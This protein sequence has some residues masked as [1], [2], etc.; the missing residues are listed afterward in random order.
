MTRRH[1]SDPSQKQASSIRRQASVTDEHTEESFA[2]QSPPQTPH[3]IIG[4]AVCADGLASLQAMLKQIPIG[5]GAAI[6]L[7][8]HNAIDTTQALIEMLSE[9]TDL[10]VN[11]VCDRERLTAD[12]I[13]LVPFGT[14]VSIFSGQFHVSSRPIT[15]INVSE[16][17]ALQPIDVFWY[18]LA[19]E[20]ADGSVGVILC[21]AQYAGPIGLRAIEDVGG[22]TI[23]QTDDP[24]E[25]DSMQ[26]IA[27]RDG[28]KSQLLGTCE[29]ADTLLARAA[30]IASATNQPHTPPQIY[31][32]T[33]HAPELNKQHLNRP[34]ENG[35]PPNGQVCCL[36]GPHQS[37]IQ[38][39]AIVLDDS[40]VIRRFTPAV[41]QIYGV[42]ES[43]IGRPLDHFKPFTDE[44]PPLP[45]WQSI[46]SGS[47]QEHS[48]C[49]HM[50][51]YFV[52]R[53]SPYR[54][55]EGDA[56]NCDREFMLL[57]FTEVTPSQGT[58]LGIA[59]RCQAFRPV[60]DAAPMV[61]AY[62]DTG[63]NFHFAKMASTGRIAPAP[64]ATSKKGAD[65]NNKLPA[66][67]WLVGNLARESIAACLGENY[68]DAMKPH[69]ES[70]L[71]GL[72]QV[73]E[74]DVCLPEDGGI[75]TKQVAY[76][77]DMGEAGNYCGCY[78]VVT[79]HQKAL[80]DVQR[81][82]QRLEHLVDAANVGIIF[83]ESDGEVVRLNDAMLDLL[84]LSREGFEAD[85]L[86]WRQLDPFVDSERGSG[87]LE[88]LLR[89]ASIVQ[90]QT[91][92]KCLDGSS[93]TVMLHGQ[94][95]LE[96][97]DEYVI[98]VSNLTP[99]LIQQQ[100]IRDSETRYRSLTQ[101]T[102]TA[103]WS[104]DARG[105]LASN[106]PLW[107]NV[108]D[109]KASQQRDLGWIDAFHPDDRSS[110]RDAWLWAVK[111]GKT[112]AI[113]ARL[114]HR[115][116]RDYR[117]VE[118]R[119]VAIQSSDGEIAQWMLAARDIH[120]AWVSQRA[121]RESQE[122]LRLALDAAEL[123]LWEWDV[124]NDCITWSKQS[125][126]R[127]ELA[128]GKVAR[129]LHAFLSM[130]HPDDRDAVEAKLTAS[131]ENGSPYRAEFRLRKSN[132]DY[133]W[134]M[135]MARVLFDHAGEPVRMIGVE[136][137]ITTRKEFETSLKQA[138]DV[139][140]A[141]NRSRGEFLANMSHEI[142]TPMTAILGYADILYDH[143]EDPDNMQC[144][145]TIRRNGHFLLEIINDIL[146]LSRIDANKFE[147]HRQFV[148]P[149]MLVADVRSLM[150]VRADEKAVNLQIEFNG[151]IPEVI[152]TDGKRLRQILLNLVGN[153]IKFTDV[154]TVTIETRYLRH[155][156]KIEFR[157]IDTGIGISKS[158]LDRLF[159]PFT[160]ADSSS[161]RSIGGTGLGLTISRRLARMLGGDIDIQTQ[162]GS[163]SVF[164]ATVDIGPHEGIKMVTPCLD[165]MRP[166]ELLHP[167]QP[168]NIHGRVLI[169]D[170]RR[171]IR[172]LAQRFV[173]EA[174][175]EVIT[176]VNGL[177]A[178][179]TIKRL[180]REGT[181]IDLVVMDMQMPVMDGY[182]AAQSLRNSGFIQPI[183]ALTADAMEGARD[184]CL[185]A[186]CNDYTPKPL[187][188]QTF[189]T[190]IAKYLQ[191]T[192]RDATRE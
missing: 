59:N 179:E 16:K 170:D 183:I 104:T 123:T 68:W 136:L 66:Q 98:F 63:L 27:T 51:Q 119:G 93:V 190:V 99:Q 168:I 182:Q 76:V 185:Q 105:H 102:A 113:E 44:M 117:M 49:T 100:R 147:I 41:K 159:E 192:L 125:T 143:L 140:E 164:T 85:G 39:A 114:Y 12:H 142:R 177:D 97:D 38:V 52:R 152:Q 161:T 26:W 48:F 188:R 19:G 172:F 81:G 5:I 171:D 42:I 109:Q 189:Q 6:V 47:T 128:P 108:T 88:M 165:K 2:P 17:C 64:E 131:L 101:I 53:V 10:T 121:L 89:E 73:Y 139:A 1:P 7:I 65:G 32:P 167:L 127:S 135:C 174:G 148:K 106:Q 55:P 134:I 129:S 91:K 58:P 130:M 94:R 24:N 87:I 169:V 145:D 82:K 90:P 23:V 175:G 112:F 62:V 22:L 138:R 178:I 8:Q 13:Y 137:D 4:V 191:C 34:L 181:N 156:N 118:V 162:F 31:A 186:G 111:R 163:G 110:F 25:D 36:H 80:Y 61:I 160:Q 184:N 74:V 122:R 151:Q 146:D 71:R 57:T 77:P 173:E 21:D 187:D 70:S 60:A 56:E 29:I 115:R 96:D 72:T 95:L 157:V 9:S 141:A 83:V 149:D 79:D 18:S 20:C 37:S 78:V 3:I 43:D 158:D 176:A 69:L 180:A 154:G 133:R 14:I 120:D 107:Q 150:Q 124:K 84:K 86:N 50:G 33:R 35:P 153:A 116:F 144:V 103:I 92:L 30:E 132:G 45:P 54:S 46:R 40:L 11:V 67:D 75:R 166:H 126:T 155:N 15:P 28:V